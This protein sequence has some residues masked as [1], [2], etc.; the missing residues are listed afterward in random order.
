MG[1]GFRIHGLRD[2]LCYLL[3]QGFGFVGLGWWVRV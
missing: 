3:V 2:V 1:L